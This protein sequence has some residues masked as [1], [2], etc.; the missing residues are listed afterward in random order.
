MARKQ[1]T[2]KSK[3]EKTLKEGFREFLIYSR[4]KNLSSNTLTYYEDCYNKFFIFLSEEALI[5][6]IDKEIYTESE[7]KLLVVKPNLKTC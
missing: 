1:I 2:L 4:A 3:K 6:E 7:I 5:S